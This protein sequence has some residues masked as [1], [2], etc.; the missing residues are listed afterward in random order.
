MLTHSTRTWPSIDTKMHPN[1]KTA[2]LSVSFICKCTGTH[3]P[4][5][6][7][8]TEMILIEVGRG[9]GNRAKTYPR[10]KLGRHT[11]IGRSIQETCQD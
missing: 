1:D 6:F 8:R 7:W 2:L 10:R 4:V 3:P 5:V 9:K 11:W